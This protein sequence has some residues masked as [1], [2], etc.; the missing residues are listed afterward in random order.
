MLAWRGVRFMRHIG[1]KHASMNSP[2]SGQYCA[3][4]AGML[5]Y[6]TSERKE[7]I[8]AITN[9]KKYNFRFYPEV[10]LGASDR[11]FHDVMNNVVVLATDWL[12]SK[13]QR[14]SHHDAL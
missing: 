1:L 8:N 9:R 2:I 14:T 3:L 10:G 12:R 5:L 6:C 4:M 11:S 13:I 7:T